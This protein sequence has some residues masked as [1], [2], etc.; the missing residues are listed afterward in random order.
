MSQKSF[1]RLLSMPRP[2][3]ASRFS[4]TTASMGYARNRGPAWATVS[5]SQATR[6]HG[7][8]ISDMNL[9]GHAG[10]AEP[11]EEFDTDTFVV[12]PLLDLLGLHGLCGKN[13]AIIL[14]WSLTQSPKTS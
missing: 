1:M 13:K 5:D 12:L 11:D 6:I 10:V 2:T 8:A 3:I 14:N 9:H 7:V 4:A